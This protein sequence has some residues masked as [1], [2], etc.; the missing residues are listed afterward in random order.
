[1]KIEEKCKCD[2]HLT[3]DALVDFQ[4]NLKERNDDDIGRIANSITQFGFTFPF[5]VW[6]KSGKNYIIDGHGRLAALM[7]LEQDGYEIP[8]LPVVYVK[9]KSAKEAKS[10]LLHV[11]SLYGKIDSDELFS[12]IKSADAN[13]IDLSF[14]QLS[15]GEEVTAFEPEV[16]PIIHKP[17]V[18]EH[19]IDWAS[20]S[21]F[22]V[23]KGIDLAEFKCRH[24]GSSIMVNKDVIKRYLK[25]AFV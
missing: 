21:A 22:D 15:F 23:V 24:C 12:L 4:G 5:F 3:L 7:K 9:A 8:P 20:V 11:N 1:M 17:D 25:G 10:L 16:N 18:T 6:R 2:A 14:P 13:V 19:D